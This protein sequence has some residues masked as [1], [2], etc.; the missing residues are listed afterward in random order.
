MKKTPP[1]NIDGVELKLCDIKPDLDDKTKFI[2]LDST[3][4]AKMQISAFVQNSVP[5]AMASV[6]G[7]L[8]TVTFPKGVPH[9]LTKLKDGSGYITAIQGVDTSGFVGHARL[10]PVDSSYA[11]AAGAFAVMSIA[12]SQYYLTEINNKLNKIQLGVDKIL[13]FLYGEKRAELMSEVT[14]AKYAYKNYASIM[15]HHDQRAA[16]I[17]GL[18]NAKKIAMKD[19]EFYISELDALSDNPGKDVPDATRKALRLKNALDIS[20]QLY[21]L[22]GLSEMY[23]SQNMDESYISYLEHEMVSYLDKSEKHI[24]QDYAKIVNPMLNYKGKENID[25][26]KKKIKDIMEELTG[27]EESKL[28]KS[29]NDALHASEKKTEFYI[30]DNGDI[31]MRADT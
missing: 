10:N 18:Q 31:Y 26:E 12:T 14:F 30:K 13:E 7:N 6:T 9:T 23:Y 29:L 3:S 8:Y 17:S 25:E 28:H 20:A 24:L 2:K 19:L 22:S 5:A 21:V 1:A 16:T 4:A 27:G 11:I 15:M